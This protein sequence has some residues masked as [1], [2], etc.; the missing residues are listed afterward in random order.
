MKGLYKRPLP[1]IGHESD[2]I[3]PAVASKNPKL[4]KKEEDEFLKGVIALQ[5]SL[6][7]ENDHP[8]TQKIAQKPP[9]KK[10][11]DE[12]AEQSNDTASDCR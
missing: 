9:P 3:L 7:T 11:A 2:I 8:P 5:T 6:L 12:K 4:L 10:A 1:Q